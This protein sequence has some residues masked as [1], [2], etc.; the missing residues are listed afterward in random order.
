LAAILV[1]CATIAACSSN[2]GSG[3]GSAVTTGGQSA[4]A[5]GGAHQVTHALG[6]TEVPDHPMRVVTFDQDLTLPT[7]LLLGVPVVGSVVPTFGDSFPTYLDASTTSKIANVGW[8]TDPNF[9]KI[10]GL[11]PDLIIGQDTTIT[12][13]YDKLSKIAPTVA[14]KRDLTDWTTNVQ[15]VADALGKSADIKTD[16]D[17]YRQRASSI[18]QQLKDAGVD[19]KPVTL[20]NIRST[21]DLRVYTS[22]CSSSALT[23]LGLSMTLAD[24][25]EQGKQFVQL[26]IEQLPQA[27]TNYLFYFVGSTGTNPGDAKS[28]YDQVSAQPLWGQLGAVKSGHAFSVNPA[29]WFNCGSVQAINRVLDDVSHDMLGQ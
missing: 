4:P 28:A 12:Q 29:W 19:D 13:S 3:S 7:A 1:A 15:A 9:E 26:S 17:A 5:D 2:S 18:K 16:L 27:D 10:A 14:I 21:D 24:K 8:W 6:T 25:T 22:N 23:D 20:L 11:H